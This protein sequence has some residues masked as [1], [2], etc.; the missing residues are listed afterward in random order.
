MR[1]TSA[2]LLLVLALALA[3]PTS[4]AADPATVRQQIVNGQ[5]KAALQQVDAELAKR[6]DDPQFQFFR[7][8]ILGA[9]NRNDQAIIIFRNLTVRYPELPEPYNN[10]AVLYA[11]EG[12]YDEARQALEM[13]VRANPDYATALENL[14]D[15]DALLA[16]QAY[17]KA[18]RLASGDAA[19]TDAK[20]RA[21][22]GML[23]AGGALAGTVSLPAPAASS[24]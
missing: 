22:D 21:I 2:I 11:R 15:V 14:G 4:W 9:E 18:G 6:P 13:A 17:R 7:G 12:R 24:P 1:Q 19:R 23:K 3:V 10:L 16:A 20:V 8:V 5:L